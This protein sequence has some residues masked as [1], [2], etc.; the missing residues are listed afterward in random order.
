MTE[1]C[2]YETPYIVKQRNVGLIIVFALVVIGGLFYV[3]WNPYYAKAFVAASKHSIG[4]SIISGKAG[5]VP[6]PSWATAI[7]YMTAYFTS[8]WKAVILG[9]LVGSLV[10]VAIPKNW[11]QRLMGSRKF[12]S[13]AAAGIT[14]LPTMMCTCC[15]APVAV[16]LRNSSASIN[17]ALAFFLGNPT[18]NPATIIFMGF[19]LG[20]NFAV[21]RI[22]MGLILVFGIS[23]LAARFSKDD[24]VDTDI[25][26]PKSETIETTENN[27]NLLVRWLKALLQLLID[28][29]PAYII[30]VAI[31]GALRAWLFPQVNPV[32]G[33]SVWAIIML[34][35]TGTLF[36]I[37]TAGEI[38]IIQT[39]MAFGLGTGPAAALLITLPAVSL[40][41][42]II[43]KRAFP[44]RVL[45]LVGIS[46]AVIGIISGFIGM[47]IL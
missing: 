45:V 2:T 29:I 18:L 3:K 46:V 15:A 7:S 20:W 38:P 22:V 41:S 6:V 8:V 19:V 40:P 47:A 5:V 12:G 31:L 25:L 4:A 27:E 10:Q 11:I 37:P 23:T 16:G 42:L 35:F 21:F 43:I 17:A 9:L 44:K 33:H 1:K 14:S 28:T 39:L 13:T 30:V 34:A 26:V 36:V 24:K 32:W